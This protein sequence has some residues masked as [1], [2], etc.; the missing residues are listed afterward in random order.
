V[1]NK[2]LTP[3]GK[4]VTIWL[5]A[6]GD[7]TIRNRRAMV[8]GNGGGGDQS[9]R[10]CS[11]CKNSESEVGRLIESPSFDGRTPAF[12]CGD[13]V[14][15]CSGM[16]EHEKQRFE[17]EVEQTAPTVA[18]AAPIGRQIDE[19]VKNLSDE[20]FRI[21]EL[22]YGLADG[23][24]YSQEEIAKLLELT[25]ERI[26]EIEAGAVAKLQTDRDAR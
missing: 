22:R 6:M 5:R 19:A 21:I 15:L 7:R 4:G 12:I 3:R 16:L 10:S 17:S 9:S 2:I 13:C 23:Y 24:M 20:E 8:Q 25:P 14:E 18:T 26:A 1:F 11:F